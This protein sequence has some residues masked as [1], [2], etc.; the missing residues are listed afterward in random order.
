MV[1]NQLNA[2]VTSNT[3][4]KFIVDTAAGNLNKKLKI[5]TDS[6]LEPTLAVMDL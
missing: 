6:L 1:L 2:H 3:T 5:T 4:I